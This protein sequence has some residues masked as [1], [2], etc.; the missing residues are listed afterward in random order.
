MNTAL[1]GKGDL[2]SDR[3]PC[4]SVPDCAGRD[5]GATNEDCFAPLAMTFFGR[6]LAEGLHYEAQYGIASRESASNVGFLRKA[7]GLGRE[8]P[9]RKSAGLLVTSR[10]TRESCISPLYAGPFLRGITGGMRD[11]RHYHSALPSDPIRY[12]DSRSKKWYQSSRTC[13]RNLGIRFPAMNRRATIISSQ[14]DERTRNAGN[15]LPKRGSRDFGPSTLTNIRPARGRRQMKADV[16]L[17][18]RG[19]AC[20]PRERADTWGCPYRRLYLTIGNRIRVIWPGITQQ[21]S[22]G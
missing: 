16:P 17:Y 10:R 13:T 12:S 14:W 11:A 15:L 20:A 2:G 18:G 9:A 6:L 5:A 21:S 8:I 19:P 1:R 7:K 4:R 22:I 3:P